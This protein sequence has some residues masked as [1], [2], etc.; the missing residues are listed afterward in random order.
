MVLIH[1]KVFYRFCFQ[2]IDPGDESLSS[3]AVPASGIQ[4]ASQPDA[5][6]NAQQKKERK[7]GRL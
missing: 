6:I 7:E 4:G 3:Q 2:F 5:A 1:Q